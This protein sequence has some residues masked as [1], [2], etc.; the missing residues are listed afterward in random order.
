MAEVLAPCGSA[1]FSKAPFTDP[2]ELR[3][4]RIA[5]TRFI[6]TSV[7]SKEHPGRLFCRETNH[8]EHPVPFSAPVLPPCLCETQAFHSYFPCTVSPAFVTCIVSLLLP[9][10]KEM[11]IVASNPLNKH[12]EKFMWDQIV[13]VWT[14]TVLLQAFYNEFVKVWPALLLIRNMNVWLYDDQRTCSGKTTEKLFK[15]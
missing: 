3:P 11:I 4:A 8:S 9:H 1:G 12:S 7:V 6:Q 5:P 2:T 14:L 13:F 15:L 10:S